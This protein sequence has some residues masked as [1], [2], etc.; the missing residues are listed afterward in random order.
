M[1]KLLLIIILSL[2]STGTYSQGCIRADIVLLAD[3]SGSVKGH[4]KYVHDALYAFVDRFELSDDGVRMSLITFNDDPVVMFPLGTDKELLLHAI[5]IVGETMPEG[6]TYM[7]GAFQSAMNEFQKRGIHRNR[8]VIVIS[9]GSPNHAYETK[10]IAKDIQFTFG[11][12][13]FGVLINTYDEDDAFMK[14]ISSPDCYVETQ[15]E[16]LANEL[17]KLDICL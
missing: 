4:Q 7:F 8:I 6:S 5:D 10:E 12:K 15:Y 13:V 3:M 2:C 16:L 11:A 1:K 14:E 17:Q 9:D